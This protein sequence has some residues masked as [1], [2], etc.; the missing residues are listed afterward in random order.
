MKNYKNDTLSEKG[1]F[2]VSKGVYGEVQGT[3]LQLKLQPFFLESWHLI[4]KI[5]RLRCKEH[6][7]L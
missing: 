7:R 3:E 4:L 1:Y 5:S 2:K 6:V